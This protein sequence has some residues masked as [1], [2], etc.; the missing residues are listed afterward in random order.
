MAT[1]AQRRAN[2]KYFKD[3]GSQVKLSMPN[4][5]AAA[6]RQYWT[7]HG[8]TVAG[9]IRDL[10]RDAISQEAVP[11]FAYGVLEDAHASPVTS[12]SREGS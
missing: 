9:F 4:E 10:V 2:K 8:L 12:I 7:D 11:G 3:N 1:E 5:E 6:L